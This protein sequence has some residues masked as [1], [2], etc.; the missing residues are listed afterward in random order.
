[1]NTVL[2]NHL[3]NNELVSNNELTLEKLIKADENAR[4]SA[5]DLIAKVSI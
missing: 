3:N 2:D 5:K 4:N 1:V